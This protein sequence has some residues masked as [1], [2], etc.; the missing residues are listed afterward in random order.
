[1][2]PIR[3]HCTVIVTRPLPEAGLCEGDV[4]IV[5]HIHRPGGEGEPAGYLLEI[6]TVEGVSVDEVS[7]PADAVRPAALM[8]RAA[9]RPVAAE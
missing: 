1:M 2:S 4:G 8:D 6:F 9:A 7:V 3:E 5:I